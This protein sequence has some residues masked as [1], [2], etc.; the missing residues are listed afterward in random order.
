MVFVALAGVGLLS[1]VKLADRTVEKVIER[2]QAKKF[3]G[4]GATE[5]FARI[6]LSWTRAEIEMI[7]ADKRYEA[8][9][10]TGQQRRKA[11]DALGQQ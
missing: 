6:N 11:H 10:I 4:E 2:E 1:L 8:L 5:E 3:Q 7:S 9:V